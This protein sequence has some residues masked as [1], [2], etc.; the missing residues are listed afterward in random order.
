M[1]K[2]CLFN[3]G[4]KDK[5]SC[6]CGRCGASCKVDPI[7]GSQARMLKRSKV[8]KGLCINCAVHDLL[9]HL[10]PA[11]LMFA[12]SGPRG[13]E[14]P[15]MQ[16]LFCDILKSA[17][18][19]AVPD[20]I[21]WQAIIDNWDLPFPTKIKRT[22]TNPVSQE[23]YDREPEED[24]KRRKYIDERMKDPRTDQEICE[25]KCKEAEGVIINLM[26]KRNEDS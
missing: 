2:Q 17:G 19:D 20:E 25:A 12:R 4:I 5:T 26:R 1:A 3:K 10:Y 14:L 6:L 16:K 21:G 15:H 22:A 18:S 24:R 13:L 7:P 8:P 23:D 9:R 11:N